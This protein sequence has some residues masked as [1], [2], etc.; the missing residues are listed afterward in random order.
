MLIL[1]NIQFLMQGDS[2]LPGTQAAIAAI[3]AYRPTRLIAF[4]Q[5]TR[6]NYRDQTLHV[7]NLLHHFPQISAC[8]WIPGNDGQKLYINWNKT[9]DRNPGIQAGP[10]GVELFEFTPPEPGIFIYAQYD[11]KIPDNDCLIIGD[12]CDRK[13]AKQLRWQYIPGENWWALQPGVIF[14]NAVVPF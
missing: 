12:G 4:G 1:V 5:P 3:A 14:N 2:P 10:I 11:Y 6:K 8:Y 7:E 13:A 9:S